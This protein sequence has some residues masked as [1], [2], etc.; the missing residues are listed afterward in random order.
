MEAT[1]RFT[2]QLFGP[3]PLQ[4]RGK[5]FPCLVPEK[6]N[7]LDT[8]ETSVAFLLFLIPGNQQ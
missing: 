6:T 2:P 5:P 1:L 7:D 3:R 4:I 8:M